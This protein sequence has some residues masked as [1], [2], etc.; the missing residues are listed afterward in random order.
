VARVS[1]EWRSLQSL[2]ALLTHPAQVVAGGGRG[3]A[4]GAALLPLLL[5]ATPDCLDRSLCY[6]PFA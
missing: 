3:G 2:A 4:A 6:T 5:S 1:L